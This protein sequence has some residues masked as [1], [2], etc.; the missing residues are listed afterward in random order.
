[1]AN[2]TK[3]NMTMEKQLNINQLPVPFYLQEMIKEFVFHDRVLYKAKLQHKENMS[4]TLD[5]IK[6]SDHY[7][8]PSFPDWN[9]NT[10]SDWGIRTWGMRTR[11][12]LLE[13]LS[14]R[15]CGDFAALPVERNRPIQY[16]GRIRCNCERR[17]DTVKFENQWA[18]YGGNR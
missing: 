13:A 10:F 7:F 2:E 17:R 15:R 3:T 14:C 16:C 12:I 4:P 5:E 6:Y 1:M 18:L 11:A 8:G 9:F